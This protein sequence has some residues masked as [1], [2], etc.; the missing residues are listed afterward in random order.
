VSAEARTALVESFELTATEAPTE[1]AAG[2]MVTG[3]IPRVT[4]FE[5]VGGSFFKD[6]ACRQPDDLADDQA[7][8]LETA[9]G[10]IVILGCAH[11]GIVNTLH[12]IRQLV[13]GRPIHTVIGGAHL[14]AADEARMNK[15]VE[16]L[17]EIGVQRLF[18]LHCTGVQA[19]ARLRKAFPDRVRSCPVGTKV[20]LAA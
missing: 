5:D 18:P 20:D 3:A 8:F 6:A 7:A 17:R 11:A 4:D 13:P 14:A 9:A 10:T 19:A 16:A 12:Y 2:L 15:T 1:V